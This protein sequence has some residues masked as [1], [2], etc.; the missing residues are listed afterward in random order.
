MIRIVLD[1][2]TP[3]T[4]AVLAD[5]MDTAAGRAWRFEDRAA[6]DL[7]H[8]QAEQIREGLEVLRQLYAPGAAR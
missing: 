1:L 8:G 3:D 4:A 5:L 6:G 2:P 7:W